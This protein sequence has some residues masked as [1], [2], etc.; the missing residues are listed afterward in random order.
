M[1]IL[2]SQQMLDAIK[3]ITDGI[4]FLK[5][6]SAL[7]HMHYACNTVQLLRLCRLPFSQTMLPTAQAE[8][9]DY[10]I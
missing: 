6:H 1:D 3:H 5:E 7:V 2:L 8:R 10:K 9:I 4:F